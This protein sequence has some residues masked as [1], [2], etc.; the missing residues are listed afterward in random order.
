MEIIKPITKANMG[1]RI[2]ADRNL[3]LTHTQKR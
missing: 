2:L 1:T 3:S